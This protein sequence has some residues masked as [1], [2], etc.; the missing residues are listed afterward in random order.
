MSELARV[1]KPGGVVICT[2]TLSHNPLI[3]WY[4]RSTPHLRTAWEVDHIIGRPS[5]S[6]F[7][8]HF[9]SCERHFFHL[10]TLAAVPL[11][12]TPLFKPVLA[13]L[14]GLDRVLL[15]IPGLRWQAWQVVFMLKGP[16]KG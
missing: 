5:F 2:E 10:A 7:E 12:T 6:I 3:R 1:L 9:A 15:S 4:R 8:K 11:R 13:V 16:K 14:R